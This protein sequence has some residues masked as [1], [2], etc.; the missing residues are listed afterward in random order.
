MGRIEQWGRWTN[1]HGASDG[2]CAW[3]SEDYLG[4]SVFSFHLFVCFGD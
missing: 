2:A 4:E 3:R 1:A